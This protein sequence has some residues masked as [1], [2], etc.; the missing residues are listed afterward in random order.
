MSHVGNF[1]HPNESQSGTG[2]APSNE[3]DPYAAPQRGRVMMIMDEN[4]NATQVTLGEYRVESVHRDSERTSDETAEEYIA[5]VHQQTMRKADT[6]RANIPAPFSN[7]KTGSDVSDDGEGGPPRTK[8]SGGAEIQF[9]HVEDEYVLDAVDTENDQY[10]RIAIP[11]SKLKDVRKVKKDLYHDKPE[12]QGSRLTTLTRAISLKGGDRVR[13]APAAETNSS[14]QSSK[15]SIAKVGR[16]MSLPK[17]KRRPLSWKTRGIIPSPT[18]PGVMSGQIP[19]DC[20]MVIQSRK[21][22]EVFLWLVACSPNRE[23]RVVL[24]ICLHVNL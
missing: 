12:R 4:G 19:Q 8:S 13:V 6:V 24:R 22:D 3:S 15:N 18:V 10:M 20:L 5:P 16:M 7:I 2:G 23:R 1:V 21:C 14:S 9:Q 17:Q 11:A